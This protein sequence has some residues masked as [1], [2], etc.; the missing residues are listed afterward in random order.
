MSES[1]SS[2]VSPSVDFEK[3]F[4][5]DWDIMI[6]I[7]AKDGIENNE[8]RG[9]TVFKKTKDIEYSVF[10]PFT[11]ISTKQEPLHS[12]LSFLF[13]GTY[14]ALEELGLVTSRLREGE[15][16]I[17]QAILSDATMLEVR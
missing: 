10:L 8:I 3:R 12:A 1:V 13:L 9:P 2:L 17:M 5:S 11:V 16:K 6:R 7:S 15:H 14:S 4:G